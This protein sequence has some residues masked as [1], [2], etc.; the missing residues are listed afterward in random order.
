MRTCA[1][2]YA[3]SER[4]IDQC[5]PFANVFDDT[6]RLLQ[7]DTSFVIGQCTTSKLGGGRRI[8]N[9]AVSLGRRLD[10]HRHIVV[11]D[12]R[13]DHPVHA[14]PAYSSHRRDETYFLAGQ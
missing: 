3:R 7:P 2:A 14:A 6:L 5:L 4:M 13:P 12:F 11:A 9:R 1:Q 8:G 10:G